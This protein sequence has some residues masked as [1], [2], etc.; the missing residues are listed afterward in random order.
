MMVRVDSVERG[1]AGIQGKSCVSWDG[2]GWLSDGGSGVLRHLDVRELVLLS[3]EEGVAQ[4]MALVLW[5]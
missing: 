3:A 4:V 1:M 2:V 5:W